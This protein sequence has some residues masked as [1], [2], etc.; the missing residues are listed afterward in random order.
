MTSQRARAAGSPSARSS[1]APRSFWPTVA[2]W[3][4]P[5]VALLGVFAFG[6][7]EAGAS[8]TTVTEKSNASFG[9]I[10]ADSTARTLYTLTNNGK[11][12]LC[13]GVCAQVWPPL[14]VPPGT[15][16]TGPP[17]VCCLGTTTNA[18]GEAVTYK[19][20][21]LYRYANDHSASDATGDGVMS[22]GG[23]WHVVRVT[24]S[25]TT[26]TTAPTATT[27][28]TVAPTPTTTG[29]GGSSS[30]SGPTASSASAPLGA[31]G[32]GGTPPRSSG[33]GVPVAVGLS[34]VG[35]GCGFWRLRRSRGAP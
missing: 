13:S 5:G 25:S 19:G 24:S 11:P 34:A 14:T 8:S 15:K 6:A 28:T 35:L 31:P 12:V 30:G 21:P 16:V 17:G 9:T 33:V 1:K 22:F 18:N 4:L 29:V 27:V 20:D 7:I 2:M 10:L 3:A 26:T 32:T 23:T